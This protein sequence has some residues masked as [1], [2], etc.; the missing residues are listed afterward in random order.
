MLY[1][2]ELPAGARTLL[3]DKVTTYMVEAV[4]AAAALALVKAD[5]SDDNDNVWDNAV[6]TEIGQ[7]L[8][9]ITF[10]IATDSPVVSVE[11]TGLAE[12]TW[13]EVGTALA[14]LLVSA[15]YTGAS[16]TK[17][18]VNE[19]SG[20][21]IIALGNPNITGV[22]ATL[23]AGGNGYEALDV[24]TLDEGTV[25]PV[26]LTEATIRVDTVTADAVATA[27]LT[28]GGTYTVA[29]DGTADPVTGG[30]GTGANFTLTW[31]E[32]LSWADLDV[33]AQI[34]A[35]GTGYT[36]GDVLTLAAGTTTEAATLE[37]TS[38]NAGAVDGVKV[39][40]PGAYSIVPGDAVGVT[41]GTG[42]DDFTLTATTLWRY[43]VASIDAVADGGHGY[44]DADEVTVVGGTSTEAAV[45]TI[46]TAVDGAVTV[47]VIKAATDGDYSVLP[48]NPVSVTG[49]GGTGATF[50]MAWD[51]G[52]N[53]GDA[54]VTMSVE[55]AAANDLTTEF[56]DELTHEGAATASLSVDILSTGTSNRILAS[57]HG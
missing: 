15:G 14:A 20:E 34:A 43:T 38:V 10:A 8:E 28:E 7:D 1:Q 41:G 17:D 42:G 53:A 36:L 49:G 2:I 56:F 32:K 44:E 50:N 11:Y 22:S 48:S 31:G 55:D 33:T 25:D 52:D 13:E 26:D 24:L 39:L 9:G 40:T 37:V 45:V 19:I 27:T 54:T 57:F 12:D 51:L 18:A 29:G 30:G 3:H 35:G 16:W 46:T 21:L 47:A 6:A 5:R 23:V 4:D